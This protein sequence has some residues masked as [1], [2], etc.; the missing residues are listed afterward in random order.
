MA[1][2]SAQGIILKVFDFRETSKIA[3]FFTE[4]HGRVTGIL[5]GIRTRPKKFG[6]SLERFSLNQIVYYQYRNTDMHLVSQCDMRSYFYPIRQDLR[7]SMAASYAM[8]LVYLMMPP[9]MPNKRI[10]RL[11]MHYLEDLQS[12]DDVDH[13]VKIFQIKALY[14]SGFRPHLDTCLQCQNKVHGRSW[15]SLQDGGLICNGCAGEQQSL[16]PISPGTVATMLTVERSSWN[17]CRRV[18]LLPKSREEL[19]YILNNF[20]VFHL[21]RKVKSAKYL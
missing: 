1:I 11:L 2:I 8:E 20:L 19:K 12:C 9:E 13:L 4:D 18:K 16:H 6:S 3:V 10:F 21:G 7:R 14:F 15:F 17:N 5:K